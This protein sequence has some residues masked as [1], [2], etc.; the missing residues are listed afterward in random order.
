[1]KTRRPDALTIGW[2][3]MPTICALTPWRIN[4]PL[5]PL[6]APID[7]VTRSIRVILSNA[8][9]GGL[10]I[11]GLPAP[12]GGPHRGRAAPAP[13]SDQR[14]LGRSRLDLPRVGAGSVFTL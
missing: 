5:A 6:T 4:A 10:V 12:G 1:M 13:G 7:S 3:A 8:T 11:M 14:K 2:S 9:R